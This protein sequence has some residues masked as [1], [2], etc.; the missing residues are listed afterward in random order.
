MNH[1]PTRHPHFR[2]IVADVLE[3][4]ARSGASWIV[5]VL[6]NG[7]E[8]ENPGVI[9][10]LNALDE[11]W[12][13]LD[14]GTDDL[15]RRL[16]RP[17]P[18]LGGVAEHVARIRRLRRPR[19]Q[20]LLWEAGDQ[21]KLASWTE[22][23]RAALLECY[24]ADPALADVPVIVLSSKEDPEAKSR[25]FRLG[26][27]DYLVKLPDRVELIA[28]IR[29]HVKAHETR[30]QRDEAYRQLAALQVELEAKNRLLEQLSRAD[31]LTGVANR[32]RFDEALDEEW[33]RAQ[34][35]SSPLALVLRYGGPSVK[36][37][38]N[39]P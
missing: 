26:A 1:E 14:C 39:G 9:E 11:A 27:T 21:A 33:R 4:R 30:R 31:G 22:G 19:L 17:L 5:N 25:A 23:N 29:A 38:R 28:R 34:R 8:L 10:A 12:L 32:R 7:S 20:T 3:L 37:A 18:E 24:R 6:S 2:E 36:S 35:D 16:S 13:K 15:Y